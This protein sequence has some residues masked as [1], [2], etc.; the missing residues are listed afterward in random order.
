[1]DSIPDLTLTKSC[2]CQLHGM[3]DSV[4]QWFCTE[5]SEGNRTI[6]LKTLWPRFFM[7]RIW[8]LWPAYMLYYGNFVNPERC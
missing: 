3:N 5:L 6:W 1:M 2:D 4:N 8:M 7:A